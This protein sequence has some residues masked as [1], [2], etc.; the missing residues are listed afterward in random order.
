[1][2]KGRWL[3]PLLCMAPLIW[4]GCRCDLAG[5]RRLP[6]FRRVL[7]AVGLVFLVLL[8]LRPAFDGWR[9]RPGD[10]NQPAGT[11][12]HALQ[13]E[14]YDGSGAIVAADRVMAG[15]LRTQFTQA[16]V[17][18]WPLGAAPPALAGEGALLM[19]ARGEDAGWLREQAAV[20]GLD[21]GGAVAGEFQLPYAHARAGQPKARYRFVLARSR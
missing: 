21:A 13:A 1:N 7:V 11:L 18:V 14:G 17:E 12:A 2:V 9:G 6:M 4:F 3:Q 15:V 20:L 5:H 16:R 19:I 8:T 10:L